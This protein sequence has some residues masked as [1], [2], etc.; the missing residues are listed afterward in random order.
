MFEREKWS[1]ERRRAHIL[2]H[3]WDKLARRLRVDGRSD[4]QGDRRRLISRARG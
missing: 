4:R 3:I 1:H 2:D